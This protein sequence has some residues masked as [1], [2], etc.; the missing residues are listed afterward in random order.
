MNFALPMP[1][2]G[3]NYVPYNFSLSPNPHTDGVPALVECLRVDNEELQAV[4]ASVLCQIAPHD[5]I[6][7][8]LTR[9]NS[10]KILIQ[11]LAS[12]IDD[13]QSRAAIVISHLAHIDDNQRVIAEQ[14]GIP[15]LVI[16]GL[17][18]CS[19]LALKFSQLVKREL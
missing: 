11:L 16:P 9:S 15:A 12:P 13:I 4:A 6:R 5:P 3:S 17:I 7:Q 10:A 18:L 19:F 8:A 14:G 2:H 1:F